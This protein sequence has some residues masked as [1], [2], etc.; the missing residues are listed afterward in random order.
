MLIDARDRKISTTELSVRCRRLGRL[1]ADRGVAPSDR[2]V[3][4][5]ANSPEFVVG[6]FALL[7]H[8]VSV[9][10]VDRALPARECSEVV[11]E[12][13]ARWML[14]DHDGLEAEFDPVRI[15]W[16]DLTALAA[17]AEAGTAAD[18]AGTADEGA[19]LDLGAWGSRPDA[20]VVWTSGSTGRP[21]G[22]VRSGAS[23]LGNSARTARRMRYRADD[24]LCPLLPFTHQYGLSMLLLWW[25]AGATLVLCPSAGTKAAVELVERHAV[26]VVDAVPASYVTLLR[27]L[28]R[29][30]AAPD[31]SSVR[32]WCVGGEPLL[33]DLRAQ[34][35]E[36]LGQPLLDGYGA[37]ELGNI[38]LAGADDPTG[39]GTPLDGVE[40]EVVDDADQAV[41]PGTA[42]QIVV[43][44]PDVMTGVLEPGGRVWPVHRPRFATGDLGYRD[45]QGRL[46]VLGRRAAVHRLGY[47]LYPDAIAHKAAGCGVPVQVVPVD[48]RRGGS[49]LVFVVADPRLRPVAHWRRLLVEQVGAHERPNRVVVVERFPGGPNGKVDRAALAE[50]AADVLGGSGQATTAPSSRIPYPERVARLHDVLDLLSSRRDEIVSVMTEVSHHVTVAGEIEAAHA[51]LTGAAAEVERHGPAAIDRMSVL[52]PSNIPLYGYVLYLLV[53]SLYTGEIVFRPSRRIADVTR[54]LHELLADAHGLPL[55]LDDSPQ[56]EFLEG[57]GA[58][59]DVL[60]FTGTYDNAE[61]VRSGLRPDQVFVFFG[62]GVN[63]FVIG[64]DAGI[65]DAVD[66]LVT[67]RMLNS[68]QDCFGPDVVFVDTA[69]SARFCSLLVRRVEKLRCGAYDDPS[70]DYGP[71]FYSDGLDSAL[72]VLRK[73]RQYIA[74]GGSVDFGHERVDPTVLIRPADTKVRP[75]ELFAPIF[76]VVPYSSEDWLDT[77]LDHPY[78]E[79]RAMGATVYGDLPET[80]ARLRRR[81]TVSVDRTLVDIDDGNVAFGGTGI[82]ANYVAH[83]R[84]RT[85]RPLLLSQVVADYFDGGDR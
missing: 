2:V 79:E 29:D 3:L 15:G 1:L 57:P 48:D 60:V 51:A 24:V 49:A 58:R 71:L 76:N 33:E 23:V 54:K 47:T 7:H 68:G 6:L 67:A 20:L 30:A 55:V 28:E 36:R 37:S 42:G 45:E 27:L 64:R 83:G 70:S 16:L 77:M 13:G 10:L 72:E 44:S 19:E 18:G 43:A 12:S 25:R 17:E 61:K 21:K 50:L 59:S 52:M 80:L 22:I 34:F 65:S 46:H 69:I 78:F 8:G 32:L 35:L 11:A 4:T 75:P 39:C 14:S 73:D 5:A 53:P 84:K 56:R 85:A 62:Q 82:R 31:L 66:G 74:A 9:A 38:A 26:T 63:P 81:H 40:V 41:P